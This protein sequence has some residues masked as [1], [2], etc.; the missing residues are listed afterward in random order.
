MRWDFIHWFR[1]VGV[2]EGGHRTFSTVSSIQNLIYGIPHLRDMFCIIEK[3][4]TTF[5]SIIFILKIV[6]YLYQLWLLKCCKNKN[7]YD[8]KIYFHSIKIT[9]Y[10]I[11]YI[12]TTLTFFYDMKIYFHSI[13]TNLYSTKY[14]FIMP[15]FFHDTKIYF[16]SVKINFCSVRNIFIIYIFFHSSKKYFH[17]MNFSFNTFLVIH[18]WSSICI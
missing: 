7:S 12:F 4:L 14:I 8:M 15:P 17:Y 10:L 16:H 9:L 5:L 1:G 2:V 6:N 3:K 18:I 11:K 13:K